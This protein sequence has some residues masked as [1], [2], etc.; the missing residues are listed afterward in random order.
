LSPLISTVSRPAIRVL[1]VDD[2]EI[3]LNYLSLV[4]VSAGYNVVAVTNAEAALDSMRQDL[5]HIVILDISMPG[6]DGLALC[7][8]IRRQT[9]PGYVY[10]MLHTA[11]EQDEDILNGMD[12][13][14]DDY[15]RK[16]ASRDQIISRLRVAQRILSH[17][18]TLMTSLEHG[19][20]IAL[21]DAPA[22]T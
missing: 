12:A 19:A 6:M 17:K 20:Q 4:V 8:A 14:A 18:H 9:Y 13:G 2:D 15:L 11:K 21:P 22:A 16:G 3:V 7:R 10:I 1:L 5:A